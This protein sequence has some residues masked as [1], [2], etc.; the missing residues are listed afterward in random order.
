MSVWSMYESMYRVCALCRHA[1]LTAPQPNA[2]KE[3]PG[4][5]F[6]EY[7]ESSETVDRGQSVSFGAKRKK[8]E[9]HLGCS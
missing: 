4:W 9:P 1:Q 3:L 7:G 2:D 6:L 8:G 5:V